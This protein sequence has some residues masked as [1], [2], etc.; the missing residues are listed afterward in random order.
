MNNNRVSRLDRYGHV[1]R[2]GVLGCPR[3]WLGVFPSLLLVASRSETQSNA[4]PPVSKEGGY[5]P[6][7]DHGVPSGVSWENDVDYMVLLAEVTGWK[8]Q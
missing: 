2:S 3:F 7:C 5:I 4:S 1:G 8:K 6:G